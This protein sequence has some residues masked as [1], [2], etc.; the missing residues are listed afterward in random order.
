MAYLD[1]NDI[2]DTL[3]STIARSFDFS[4][5]SRRTEVIVFMF[6]P[7]LVA[8]A[9]LLPLDFLI[10]LRLPQA[11]DSLLTWLLAF[12]MIALFARRLHDQ[13]RSGMWALLLV[14]GIIY[15]AARQWEFRTNPA[16]YYTEW[17]PLFWSN[18][19]IVLAILTLHFWPGTD[20]ANGY[21]PDPRD[22]S[23][24]ETAPA[25]SSKSL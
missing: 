3:R 18:A 13:D 25:T 8:M 2:F 12:P 15:S 14:P 5:R 4:G 22:G 20:G 11:I 17:G 16:F 23:D 24:G 7:P 9:I 6:V 1:R 19:I 10:G 21:G